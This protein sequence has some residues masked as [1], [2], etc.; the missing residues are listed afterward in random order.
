MWKVCPECKK[1][2]TV[3]KVSFPTEQ[4]ETARLSPYWVDGKYDLEDFYLDIEEEWNRYRGRASIVKCS[5][6]DHVYTGTSF[7]DAWKEMVWRKR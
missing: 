4:H 1:C 6:C 5:C 2:D 7:E 3:I